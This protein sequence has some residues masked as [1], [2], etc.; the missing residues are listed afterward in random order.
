[1]LLYSMW[2]LL[3]NDRLARFWAVGM[4]LAAIP[5]SA[6]LPMDRLLTFPGI[7]AFGLLAQFLT[8]ALAGA[9]RA[10]P[11]APRRVLVTSLAWFLVAVHAVV[12]PMVLP[13]RAANPVGP[14]WI[15]D[16]LYVNTPLEPSLG[17]RTIV[18][19]NAPSPV[20][21]CY[22]ILRRELSGK[23][24]PRYTRVLAPAFPSVA[25][26]RV[27]ERTLAIR[28]K[29]GYLKWVLDQVFRSE[30]K[31]LSLG[32][33]VMLTGMTATITSLTADGRPAEVTFRF[34]VPLESSSLLW[35]CYRAGGFE[36]FTPPAVGGEIEI[37]FDWQALLSPR[38][39]APRSPAD[40]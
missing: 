36:P 13:F 20:N 22:L 18:I 21:A 16:R 1:L 4:V 2:P 26:R 10:S 25:I 33:R 6:T 28:P 24:V 32:E 8:F 19:V 12:A 11:Y 37:P 7:G 27:D 39:R 30:R 3:R 15:E 34:D 40:P 14:R 38:P 35:L 17:D 23:S 31:P 9:G 29:G 5:V